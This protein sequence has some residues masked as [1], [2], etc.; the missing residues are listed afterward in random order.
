MAKSRGKAENI[1]DMN[2]LSDELNGNENTTY[3]N[4]QDAATVVLSS[5]CPASNA[6]IRKNK[7][8]TLIM[9]ASTLRN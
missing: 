5:K 7:G 9:K 2:P 6:C 1:L 8:L 3:P 4:L